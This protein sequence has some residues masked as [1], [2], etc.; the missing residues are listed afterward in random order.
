MIVQV[1]WEVKVREQ[2]YDY[3]KSIS[4]RIEGLLPSVQLATRE[5]RL[6]WHEDVTYYPPGRCNITYPAP[7]VLSPPSAS[8]SSRPGTCSTPAIVLSPCPDDGRATNSEMTSGSK[9]LDARVF[10]FTDVVIIARKL[11][12]KRS[13]G[14]QWKLVSDTG[15]ARIVGMVP[16]DATSGTSMLDV[17]RRYS[18][19]LT[20]DIIERLSLDLLP[21]KQPDL[22]SGKI[23]EDRSVVKVGLST[24]S[25]LA[26]ND[27]DTMLDAFRRCY[28]YTLRS[29]SFP[30]HSA[31]YLPHGPHVDLEQDTQTS[32]IAIL[33]TGLPLP[34]SPS[35]QIHDS[36]R[37]GTAD[38]STDH[39]K[40]REE[41]GWW[42][43]RF[44]Q[45]LKEMQRQDPVVSLHTT[46]HHDSVS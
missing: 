8:S 42:A 10:V 41:R 43:L 32:V 2:E 14:A 28:A 36:G 3:V 17:I 44:Q 24:P 13:S 15:I 34:K 20:L 29:L 37:A 16:P 21:L 4:S 9:P 26:Q 1:L 46:V 6:L 39:D 23:P 11:S 33:N 7:A 19:I 27:H 45:V 12:K 5:R 25:R 31:Q 18:V 38:P 30:S 22:Q 35:I 40:E